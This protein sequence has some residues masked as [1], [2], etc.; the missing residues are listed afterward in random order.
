MKILLI[1]IGTR[2]DMEPF[3]AIGEILEK[4]GHQVLY[5]FPEQFKTLIESSKKKFLSLGEEY[6]RML[7]SDKG[8]AVLGG[9]GSGFKKFIANIRLAKSSTGINKKLVI[10][11]YEIIKN[12]KPDRVLY[13]GKAIYPLL[14]EID[15]KGRTILISP[16][17]YLHYVE[18]HSHIGFHGN[19]GNFL[20]KLTFSLA[21]F[22]LIITARISAKWLNIAGTI[23]RKH[24]KDA[25]VSRK[26]IYTISPYLF[27]RPSYWNENI[28]VLG[29]HER[30]K[31]INWKPERSLEHFISRHNKILFITFGSMIDPKP[32]K[33]TKIFLDILEKHTIPTIINT[34]SGGLARPS[35]Y[36]AELF[37]FVEQIPYD[38]VF[39]KIHAVIHHG[40]SGTTHASLK[41]GCSTMI[42][43]HII[44]QYAW[45]DIVKDLEVGPGGIAKSKIKSKNLEPKLLHLF[46]NQAYKKK[47]YEISKKIKP[48]HLSDILYKTILE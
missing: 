45:N 48:E 26:V 16:V 12:E 44:D 38:W 30:D 9:S 18:G 11:Q 19:F 22:G 31:T 6:V 41:H 17:P 35:D 33:M 1:S 5:A 36:N 2:G 29:Y 46:Q 24:I 40:G 42:I 34:A 3:L 15:N 10:R 21:D 8:K 37:Y 4:K 32:E 43:P 25:L 20:N 23:S 27:P 14:W 39:P 7:D 28:K 13:N 47:A